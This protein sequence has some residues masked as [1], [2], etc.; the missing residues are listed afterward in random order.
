MLAC[1]DGIFTGSGQNLPRRRIPDTNIGVKTAG[2]NSL[3]V[4]GNGVDLTKMALECLQTPPFRYA[5]DSG[6]CIVASGNHNVAFNL[7]AAD[8]RLVTQ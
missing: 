4:K 8:A 3:A 5:P 7:E 2:N 1:L 6:K